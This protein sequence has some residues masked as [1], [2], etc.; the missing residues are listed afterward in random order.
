[1]ITFLASGAVAIAL[2]VSGVGQSSAPDE[3]LPRIAASAGVSYELAEV[4][5]GAKVE[6]HSA[7]DG[8]IVATLGARTEFDSARTFY[9]AKRRGDW[10]GVPAAALPDG[11]LGWIRDDPAQ[12]DF[13]S[14]SYSLHAD[15]SQ[16]SIDLRYGKRLVSRI[17]VTVGAVGT[18]TPPGTFSVTDGLAGR[19]IGPWY[20]CCILALTGHQANLPSDWLGG[21]RIAIHGTPGPVGGA[22]SH[23]C[24][25]ASNADM[26][27]LFALVPLGAP[28]F[29]RE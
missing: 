21:N 16:Q 7:P 29:V 8:P 4:R 15:L 18:T 24:L 13:G 5:E 23:G 12:L 11:Q 9:V 17:P 20:G 27:T 19:N 14:T 3:L 2:L 26:V 10:L 25:R 22:A 28:V 6:L 1:L